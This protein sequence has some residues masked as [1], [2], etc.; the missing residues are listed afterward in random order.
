MRRERPLHSCA[1]SLGPPAAGILKPGAVEPAASWVAR[2][3]GALDGPGFRVPRPVP[4]RSGARVVEGWAAWE[5]V[6]GEPGLKGHPAAFVR[7]P[8]RPRWSRPPWLGREVNPSATGDRVAWGEETVPVAAEL[9]T[10]MRCPLRCARVR[11]AP[12]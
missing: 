7:A 5:R 9:G 11:S 8:C 2:L 3:I 4:A 12:R 10:S 1:A 6:E